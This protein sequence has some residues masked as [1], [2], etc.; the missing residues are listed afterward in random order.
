[1]NL[2][3][4]LLEQKDI[5]EFWKD[6]ET[7]T[8]AITTHYIRCIVH[9]II[10]IYDE[11]V[12]YKH[13]ASPVLIWIYTYI[14]HGAILT[15]CPGRVFGCRSCPWWSCTVTSWWRRVVR[16]AAPKRRGRVRGAEHSVAVGPV[17]RENGWDADGGPGRGFGRRAGKTIA[18]NNN[19]KK[20]SNKHG[21]RDFLRRTVVAWKLAAFAEHRRAVVMSSATAAAT[22]G[23]TLII[24]YTRYDDDDA[25]ARVFS[26][27]GARH[28]CARARR[29]PPTRSE[30]ARCDGWPTARRLPAGRVV[31][32]PV[33]RGR[34]RT[35]RTTTRRTHR[36]HE[37]RS[38]TWHVVVL[39]G[40]H[41]PPTAVSEGWRWVEGSAAPASKD[42]CPPS[43]RVARL[44]VPKLW[45]KTIC[46]L[47]R[48]FFFFLAL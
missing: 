28:V 12:S 10:R 17:C 35:G 40:R 43:F 9:G 46:S 39:V 19:R 27:V 5:G 34:R 13:R 31:L 21:F 1:M 36:P 23:P 2:Y 47:G 6:N 18:K 14:Y 24:N 3:L 42:P 33:A 37:C 41:P 16:S 48:Q 26:F 44:T 30:R 4:I 22:D 15:F 25:D 8:K 38:D 20:K 7:K 29:P 32:R 45:L 11:G